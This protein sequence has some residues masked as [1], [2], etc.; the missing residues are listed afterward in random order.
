MKTN[1]GSLP[2]AHDF[3]LRLVPQLYPQKQSTNIGGNRYPDV[4]VM[5][6]QHASISCLRIPMY[7]LLARRT[8]I[9]EAP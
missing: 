9:P 2:C 4:K 6:S 1:Q 8:K 7:L 5:L 3:D